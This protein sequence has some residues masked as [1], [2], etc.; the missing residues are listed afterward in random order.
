MRKLIVVG[1][2]VLAA[3]N[4]TSG[5]KP[6]QPNS[7][8]TV[9]LQAVSS[10]M[11]TGTTQQLQA[12]V[13]D[14]SGKTNRTATVTWT[15]EPSS[16]A[17][18]SASG[19]LTAVAPG[20]VKVTA[21]SNGLSDEADLQVVANPCTT[22]LALSVGEVRTFTGSA[23]VA[24]V[25]I[26]ASTSPA[27]YLVIGANVKPAQD[28]LLPFNMSANN[29]ASANVSSA[30]RV[31]SYDLRALTAELADDHVEALHLKLRDAERR[32][33]APVMR[34]AALRAAN[35][36]A[37]GIEPSRSVAA[38]AIAGVGDT[39][40][41]KVPNLNSGKDIC[42]DA[43][44]IRAV[45]RTVS[46]RA[47]IVEDITSPGGGFT[48]ADYN[49]IASEFDNLIFPTDTAW[50]GKPTDIN[51]DGHI[52]I[53]YTPEVNKLAPPNATGFTAGFFFGNDLLRKTDFTSASDCKNSTNEQEIFYVLSA[54]PT[55]QFNNVRS[56]TTVRQGTRGVIAHEFQ[57][58]INQS[59]RQ[60]NPAVEAL[61]VAWLNEGLSHLAE[62]VVGRAARNFGDFQSLSYA[63]VNPDATNA[64][65]YN[66]FF[67]QNILRFRNWMQHPDTSAPISVRNRDQ[68]APRGASWALLRY[69][70]D[71]YSNG[72][73]RAFTR[74]LDSGPQTDV[75]NLLARA[76]VAQF[77]QIIAGWL[78]ANYAD[79]LGIANL[80]T[81]YSYTSWNMR[82]VE[83]Q[84]N[85][86]A[87]PLAVTP[88]GAA[89]NSQAYSS[90][91]SFF[92]VS[93]NTSP[94][95]QLKMLST[96][97]ATLTNEYATMIVVRLN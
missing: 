15:A 46:T 92:R 75:A 45:V 90:S 7:K 69:T 82:D 62:E 23:T 78:V 54:D 21:K 48:S 12:A 22:A 17:T 35:N 40:T 27:D 81:K 74:A 97:G 25:S 52:T 73:A 50:F 44:S 26:A 36:A 91:G 14:S 19:L 60:Y 86:G 32:L 2:I 87:F 76:N 89:A 18:V 95:I 9:V 30:A 38:A 51:N 64:N 42:R 56:T 96:G 49:A 6:G 85:N 59:V 20:T 34:Q 11:V 79:N 67:R 24:C 88:L 4:D 10:N 39:V 5:P 70:I 29:T 1:A 84:A 58:M 3:C 61:E 77:D 93:R 8:G 28:D 16:V 57:H 53:L 80:A 63:D 13:T 94:T 37:L 43:I 41:I 55:G 65:D 33:V 72:N 47:I 66:A 71:Q 83:S 31:S 68:L